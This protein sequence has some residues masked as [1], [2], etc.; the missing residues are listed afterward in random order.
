[1]CPLQSSLAKTAC[2]AQLLQTLETSYMCISCLTSFD[3][4][5]APDVK[6]LDEF[7]TII[8][9]AGGRLHAIAQSTTCYT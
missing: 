6:A 7:V 1:M 4:A 5:H 9:E 8:F 2:K 3:P